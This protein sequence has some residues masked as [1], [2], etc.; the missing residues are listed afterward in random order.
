MS[1]WL[2]VIPWTVAHQAPL[3]MRF[4]RQ[5]YWSGLAFPALGD[6]PNPGI[7]PGSPALQA[8]SLPAEPPRKPSSSETWH[9]SFSQGNQ[10]RAQWLTRRIL[11][12]LHASVC[13]IWTKLKVC[14]YW[15]IWLLFVPWWK[16]REKT[17]DWVRSI[18]VGPTLGTRVA[19]GV[20]TAFPLK[21]SPAL[22]QRLPLS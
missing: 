18:G 11:I 2:C 13:H 21:R 7:E 15:H 6:L 9:K 19:L 16:W 3:C 20:N 4:S 5:E 1:D 17:K 8:H 14:I 12:E 10:N 22:D